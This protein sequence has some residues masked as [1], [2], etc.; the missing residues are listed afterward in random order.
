MFKKKID[1]QLL[2]RH[3]SEKT[4]VNSRKKGLYKKMPWHQLP[5]ELI[6]EYQLFVVYC[7]LGVDRTVK[8]AYHVYKHSQGEEPSEKIPYIFS[9]CYRQFKWAERALEWDKY[10]TKQSFIQSDI[11]YKNQIKRYKQ[12]LLDDAERFHQAGSKLLG[13]TKRR[14]S[15]IEQVERSLPKV[16]EDLTAK[17]LKAV[18]GCYNLSELANTIAKSVDIVAE[19]NNQTGK[20]LCVDKLLQKWSVA[21][22]GSFE[23]ESEQAV[24]EQ[25]HDILEQIDNL[26][27]DE[28][29]SLDPENYEQQVHQTQQFTSNVVDFSDHQINNNVVTKNKRQSTKLS[30]TND[31]Q[32]SLFDLID[33][34]NQET[35]KPKKL[36]QI[37]FHPDDII[38]DITANDISE[39]KSDLELEIERMEKEDL[40]LELGDSLDLISS[41]Y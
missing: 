30:V 15:R 31:A 21:I 3:A 22:G 36:K 18:A 13:I 6:N 35:Y 37:D 12:I 33:N 4:G 11:L 14:L 28:L 23:S 1:N 7:E 38:I 27:S 29:N 5:D 39:N 8:K 40:E 34:T 10:Q 9:R 20:A 2:T 26:I 24:E 19:S 32:L 25:T 17:E 41:N 16:S